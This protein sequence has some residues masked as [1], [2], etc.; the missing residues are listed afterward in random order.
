M[1]IATEAD[2]A[3][4][5]AFAN[6]NNLRVTLEISDTLEISK[7][8]YIKA[9]VSLAGSGRLRYRTNGLLIWQGKTSGAYSL[10][11]NPFSE[12]IKSDAPVLPGAYIL[13]E[14][15]DKI[16]IE[17]HTLGGQQHPQELHQVNYA[18]G[19]LI[20]VESFVVDG[21]S[22]GTVSILEPI[23]NISITGL[24]LEFED[25][26]QRPYSTAIKFDGVVNSTIEGIRCPRSGPGAIWLNNSYNCKVQAR[27]DGTAASDNV[28]GL[29]VGTVNNVQIYD[30]LIT[31]CRH[32]FTTTAGKSIGNERWGTPL[33]VE[34]RNSIINV[35][36]KLDIGPNATRVGL[37]T[38]AEGYEVTF[39][40]VTVNIGS[41]T[42]NYG[43]FIRSRAPQF[44]GCKFNGGPQTKAIEIYAP[45]AVIDHCLIDRGWIGVAAK[46]IYNTFVS[47]TSVTNTLFRNLAGPACFFEAGDKHVIHNLAFDRVMTNPGSKFKQ[48]QTAVI[49]PHT[50]I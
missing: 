24:E 44:L 33:N 49:G 23:D 31:G 38:H 8:H 30:S 42:A 12:T 9:P 5:I 37:D 29:V 47:H 14:S 21:M 32:T 11:A 10:E 46:K 6:Q 36:T 1:S 19:G 17:P 26:V 2:F 13:C 4:A 41:G 3:A 20:G 28:Y 22:N 43:A 40:D 39:R 25:K 18:K 35:P 7:P 48:Y 15:N 34:L 50:A 16:A 27:I 45:D